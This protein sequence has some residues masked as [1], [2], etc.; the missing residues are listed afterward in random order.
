[1][2][3]SPFQGVFD[4]L[5]LDIDL[6]LTMTRPGPGPRQEQ[7]PSLT[8]TGYFRG[9]K[10]GLF[11]IFFLSKKQQKLQKGRKLENFA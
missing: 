9:C 8:I 11:V 10:E 6:T 4:I 7:D 1:M 5:R 3:R 2:E